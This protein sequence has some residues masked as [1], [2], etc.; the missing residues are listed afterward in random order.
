ML[1]MRNKLREQNDL[2]KVTE[3][4]TGRVKKFT[5]FHLTMILLPESQVK[6]KRQILTNTDKAGIQ[7]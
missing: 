6:P 5:S 4:I 1:Q 3:S 7:N 2:Q